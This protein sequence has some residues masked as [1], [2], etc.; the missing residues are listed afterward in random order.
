[1]SLCWPSRILKG[2]EC[3]PANRQ[4]NLLGSVHGCFL[5]LF[6]LGKHCWG[7]EWV[8]ELWG[9]HWW[10]AGGEAGGNTPLGS[11]A[12]HLSRR[13]IVFAEWVAAARGG[14]SRSLCFLPSCAPGNFWNLLTW[15]NITV[16][17]KASCGSNVDRHS[18]A[19]QYTCSFSFTASTR[20]ILATQ[21][22]SV[23]GAAVEVLANN[24]SLSQSLGSWCVIYRS[25]GHR[26][27]KWELYFCCVAGCLCGRTVTFFPTIKTL[28][29]RS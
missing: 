5:F 23:C 16:V 20:S 24:L 19:Q 25:Q 17:K 18:E 29:W 1:M 21:L 9:Q 11:G 27:L 8:R 22:I 4:G 26:C 28:I 15:T 7:N 2:L 6:E 3:F 12:I 14:S 13:C 10:S